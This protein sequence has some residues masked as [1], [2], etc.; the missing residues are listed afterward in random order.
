ML[1]SLPPLQRG[2][3][4]AAITGHPLLRLYSLC[5]RLELYVS[6]QLWASLSRCASCYMCLKMRHLLQHASLP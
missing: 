6:H 5:A 1:A 4:G 2:R 3:G